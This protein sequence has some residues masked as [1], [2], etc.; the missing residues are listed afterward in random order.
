MKKL[1]EMVPT[2]TYYTSIT[3]TVQ[4]EFTGQTYIE[5]SQLFLF[6]LPARLLNQSFQTYQVV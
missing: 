4:Q 2:P 1:R 6:N 5:T 3:Q